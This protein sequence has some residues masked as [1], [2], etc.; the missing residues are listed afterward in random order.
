MVTQSDKWPMQGRPVLVTGGVGHQT[1]R[2]L[3]RWGAQVLITG[4][5][6]TTGEQ[7]A[8]AIRRESGQELV[9]FLQADHATVGG[10]QRLADQ[11]RTAVPGWMC[12]WT[13]SAGCTRPAG[14]R[15]TGTRPPWP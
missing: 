15:P 8:A 13:T 14:R 3:A 4:R 7:A 11:V 2:L 5:E 9:R 12:W 1:A 10:N 6:P